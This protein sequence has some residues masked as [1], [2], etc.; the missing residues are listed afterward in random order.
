MTLRELLAACMTLQ[1]KVYALRFKETSQQPM[2]HTYDAQFFI[3]NPI[4]LEISVKLTNKKPCL[5]G[6]ACAACIT[7]CG[8]GTSLAYSFYKMS[9]AESAADQLL[10]GGSCLAS[11]FV[12]CVLQAVACMAIK[13]C[14]NTIAYDFSHFNQVTSDL[15]QY[16]NNIAK[17]STHLLD[18]FNSEEL[19]KHLFD[20]VSA[21]EDLQINE[22]YDVLNDKKKN[23]LSFLV[24][25]SA[26]VI[27]YLETE[28]IITNNLTITP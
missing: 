23:I 16:L 14:C 27:N 20:F 17:Q 4:S 6:C 21:M 2:T 18:E 12:C 24:E 13:K 7:S 15:V 5:A 9:M 1:K 26:V 25:F 19:N 10:Y 28:H 3:E 11:A 22:I 8:G